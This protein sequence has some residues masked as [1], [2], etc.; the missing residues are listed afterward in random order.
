MKLASFEAAGCRRYGFVEGDGIVALD[1]LPGAANSLRGWIA[2]GMQV[3]PMS[4]PGDI[5]RFALDGVNMLPPIW[6]AG[7]IFCVAVNF[8]EPAREGK[9]LP[10]YPL[11][12]TRYADSLVG[13]GAPMLK[14]DQSDQYDYEGEV[15]VIIGKYGRHIAEENAASYVAGY[16][17]VNDGSVRDWQKHSTQFTPGKNFWRSGS[18]GPW[19]VTADEIPDPSVLRLETRVNGEVRQAISLDSFIFGIPWLIAYLSSFTPLSPG[20][21]IV[22]G[23]PT[24][25][26]SSRQP[27][28]FLRPGDVVEV[29]VPGIGVLRNAVMAADH[30][31]KYM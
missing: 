19:M 28:V 27:A 20:D 10:E 16:A 12:F 23:T 6:D 5:E 7:K 17:C 14:P 30:F 26:G 13:H 3:D 11:L 8:H 2:S 4:L 25:F 18:F 22:T 29:E 1:R 15:A 21:V 31:R 24:G 9:P